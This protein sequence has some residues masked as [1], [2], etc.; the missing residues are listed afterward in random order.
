[1]GETWIPSEE[2]GDGIMAEGKGAWVEEK[3][4]HKLMKTAEELYGLLMGYEQGLD[5]HIQSYIK[6]VRR[7]IIEK[8]E[9]P[10]HNIWFSEKDL[11]NI[12]EI[13]EG[14]VKFASQTLSKKRARAQIEPEKESAEHQHID[15]RCR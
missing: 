5:A 4:T 9:N 7:G 12:K 6:A 1:M 14:L 8:T 13:G 2:E 10:T 3:N 15:A 11:L